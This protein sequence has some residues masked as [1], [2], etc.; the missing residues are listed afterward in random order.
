MNRYV[1]PF[2]L[3]IYV[4]RMNSLIFIN[5]VISALPAQSAVIAPSNATTFFTRAFVRGESCRES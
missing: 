4:I 5:P 3:K 2:L 1:I